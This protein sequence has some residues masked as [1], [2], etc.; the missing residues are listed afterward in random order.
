MRSQLRLRVLLPV[1][2]LALLGLGVGAFA[3]GGAPAAGDDPLPQAALKSAG[4]STEPAAGAAPVAK[5]VWAK[6]ANELCRGV[7]E[8]AA[9]LGEP[10]TPQEYQ[11]FLTKSVELNRNLVTQLAALP[12]PKGERARIGSVLSLVTR[13]NDLVGQAQQALGRQESRT[14]VELMDKSMA[15]NKKADRG[16]AAL[17]AR[18][19]AKDSSTGMSELERRL[20]ENPVLVVVLYS[21]E[22]TVDRLAIREA[23]A[24]A[25]AV[26]AG[27]LAVDVS[28][29]RALKAIG[30]EHG[31]R[32]APSV[33]VY[34][35]WLGVVT[36]ISGFADRE[37]VAQAAENARA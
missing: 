3:F 9:A 11:E 24:G 34:A 7:L 14:F 37:T 25:D 36:T 23:R 30:A 13:M 21:P 26:D 16:A 4:T 35:R 18:V 1:A 27:F 10:K 22:A 19:C 15:L 28:S 5:S 17:G 32:E 12:Q 29:N 8:Q 20:L 2:V 31:I 33:L 6:Q